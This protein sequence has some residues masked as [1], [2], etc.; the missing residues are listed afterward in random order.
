MH[1]L[2]TLAGYAGQEKNLELDKVVW[3]MHVT[4]VLNEKKKLNS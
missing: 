4:N 2:P 1:A 3:S